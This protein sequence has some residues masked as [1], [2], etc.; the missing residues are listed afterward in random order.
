MS[1]A[2]RF[3]MLAWAFPA[4]LF[5]VFIASFFDVIVGWLTYLGRRDDA[6]VW[7]LNERA[8]KWINT[9][10][11]GFHNALVV[12]NIIVLR[13]Y[14]DDDRSAFVIRHELEHVKQWMTLGIF[15]PIAYMLCWLVLQTSRHAHPTYDHPM[16]IDARRAAGQVVDVIGALKRLAEHGKLP[17]HH[18]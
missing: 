15:M 1:K 12:G 13:H 14:I 3:L 10:L 16:E 5:G 9:R 6:I 18:K 2:I 17:K 4:T 7:S 8:P 11:F